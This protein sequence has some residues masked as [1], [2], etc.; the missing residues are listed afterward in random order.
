MNDDYI[1]QL[2]AEIYAELKKQKEEKK[3]LNKEKNRYIP[4]PMTAEQAAARIESQRK[5]MTG[6]EHSQATKDL[7]ARSSKGQRTKPV[8]ISTPKGEFETIAAASKAYGIT[9]AA[10]HHKLKHG[11]EG[12]EYLDRES[13]YVVDPMKNTRPIIAPDGTYFNSL[14]D[15]FRAGHNGYAIRESMNNGTGWHYADNKP[16]KKYKTKNSI[17]MGDDE[18]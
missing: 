12:W 1:A 8:A 9:P 15:A 4:H 6:R 16:A 3:K 2:R 13:E 14:T 7:M 17:D 10:V 11:K 5:A 18:C